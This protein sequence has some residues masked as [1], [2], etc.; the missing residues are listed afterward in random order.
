MNETNTEGAV[1]GDVIP[2]ADPDADLKDV[3]A[4]DLID[5]L[6]RRGWEPS[7]P[8]EG[9]RCLLEPA[10]CAQARIHEGT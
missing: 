6:V 4:G 5:E 7:T 10:A 2:A 1:V 9:R 8:T 3:G